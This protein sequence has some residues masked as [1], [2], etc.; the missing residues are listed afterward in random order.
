M[1]KYE[2]NRQNDGEP[3]LG[4]LQPFELAGPIDAIAGRQLHVLADAL[5][6]FLH[7]AGEVAAAHA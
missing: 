7:R 1:M 5:L 4:L 2:R 3:F 6:G